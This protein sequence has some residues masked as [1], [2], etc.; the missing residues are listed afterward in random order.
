V[1]GVTPPPSVNDAHCLIEAIFVWLFPLMKRLA[2]C[3]VLLLPTSSTAYAEFTGLVVSILDG[4]TRWQ[5][6][7][8][9]KST[10]NA[11]M[12]VQKIQRKRVPEISD[13][14]YPGTLPSG[15][16]AKKKSH[17]YL[18]AECKNYN[19]MLTQKNVVRIDTVEDAVEAGYHPAND[20]PGDI[21]T[22]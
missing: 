14:Q 3:I 7:A 18:Y 2:V 19:A 10:S 22:R 4:S 17:V 15:V 5:T 16:L 21:A 8:M 1:D 20:C 13:F 11:A 12:G 6:G 9:G